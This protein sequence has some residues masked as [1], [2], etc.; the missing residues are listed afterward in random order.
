MPEKSGLLNKQIKLPFAG[1]TKKI[2][3]RTPQV[4]ALLA[5]GLFVLAPAAMAVCGIIN[6]SVDGVLLFHPRFIK[7]YIWPAAAVCA[8][9]AMITAFL[10]LRNY[11]GGVFKRLK[12]APVFALFAALALWMLISQTV[13]EWGYLARYGAEGREETAFMQLGCIALLFPAGALITGKTAKLRLVRL[14]LAVSILLVVCA[15]TVWKADSKLSLITEWRS[16][17]SSIYT[18][19]NYYGYYLSLSVPAA[20][21]CLVLENRARWKIFAAA[22]LAANSAAMYINSTTG[23][24]VACAFALVFVFFTRLYIE[25]KFN[26]YVALSV[27]VFAA[28]MLVTHFILR[29]GGAPEAN[30]GNV[31]KLVSD[32]GSIIKGAESAPRAGSGRWG[33]WKAVV[34]LIGEKPVFG[35]GMEALYTSGL[36]SAVQNTRP[37]NEFLQ[38]ALFYGVP[39]ALL[40]VCGCLGVFLRGRRLRAKLCPAAY[41][42]LAAAFGYL[43]SSFFGN[44]LY[45]INP[46]FF[47]FL[48][49]G[50]CQTENSDEPPRGE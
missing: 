50:Y 4:F 28:S 32:I 46:L 17:F 26:L 36:E 25:K 20:A 13:N 42:C 35:Y 2:P 38:Y 6:R 15:F 19:T 9:L 7:S 30:A 27:A 43:V 44:T 34:T 5:A 29:A 22:A 49:M 48:G 16:C 11:G 47:L 21:A 12:S 37:H 41:I 31:E 10:N 40:Y 14:H 1:V 8:L 3:A 18:N 23:A 39:A 24:W 45:C 33:I